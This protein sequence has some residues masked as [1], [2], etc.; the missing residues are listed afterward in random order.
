MGI[1]RCGLL[2]LLGAALLLPGCDDD[3]APPTFEVRISAEPE[4]GGN[5]PLT[6]RFHAPNNGPLEVDYTYAW[7]FGG[8]ATSDEAEPEHTFATPGEHTVSVT[9]R[10]GGASG[11]TSTT[12]SLAPPADLAVEEPGFQ[13]RRVQAGEALEATWLLR[14]AGADPAAGW[15]LQAFASADQ[16]FDASDLVIYERRFEAGPVDGSGTFTFD[17]PDTLPSGDYFVGVVADPDGR[18]GDSNRANNVAF[19]TFTLQVRNPT[20]DG[21]DLVPC[22]LA[23]PAFDRLPPDQVPIAQ[24]GDQL[25]VQVCM[26]NVGDGVVPVAGYGLF[27]SADEVFDDGDLQVGRRDGFALGTGD[28][29]T[30]DDLID[31]PAMDAVGT[32]HLLVVADAREAVG[33]QREDNNTRAWPG[34]FALAEAGQVAGVDLALTELS[35][36]EDRAFWGQQLTGTL[37]LANRGD[38]AVERSFVIRLFAVPTGPGDA[39]QLRS[40]NVPGFAAGASEAFDLQLPVNRRLAAGS[41]V[42]RGEVDPGGSTDDVNPANNQRTLQRELQL[43]G[44]PDFDLVMEAVGFAPAQ[45]DAGDQ[46][47]VTGQVSNPGVDASGG[48]EVAVV[49]SADARLDPDDP[50]LDLT[51]VASIPGGMTAAIERTVVVPLDLDQAVDTWQVILVADPANRL[52]GERSEEN[53]AG[54]APTPLVVQGAMG[55]CAEDQANEP[56]DVRA[57][58]TAVAA[59]TLQ[60]L[61]LCDDADW[62][63]V[64]VGAGQVLEVAVSHDPAAGRA[65]LRVVDGD[66]AA[67]A[68]GEGEAGQVGAFVEPR[69]GA[70]R[71]YVEVTADG[72]LAYDL[73]VTL[74]DAADAP[75]LRLSGV[76][77]QPG[78]VEPGGSFLVRHTVHNLGL[79]AAGESQIGVALVPADGGAPIALPP[80]TTAALEGGQRVTD[81]VRVTLPQ[82]VPDGLYRVRLTAD[83]AETVDEAD[84]ANNVAFGTLRV[85]EAQACPEDDFEPNASGLEGPALGA[86][87]LPPGEHADLAACRGNDDW[88]Q[89]AVAEG[90]RLQVTARFD[91]AQGDLELALYGPDGQTVLD[92][93]ESFRDEESVVLLRAPAAG[94]YF[95]RVYLS[96][97]DAINTSNGYRLTVAVED[98]DDCMDDGFEPNGNRDSA[99]LLPDGN[100]DLMLCAGDEDWFRF[101]IPVGNTV[102]FQVASGAAGV[103]IALFGPDGALIEEDGR[104]I[105]H[106]A[107]R[108]GE[109]RLRAAVVA[110][111]PVVYSL[112]VAGVSGTDLEV[113]DVALSSAQAEAGQDLR[114]VTTIANNRGDGAVNVRVRYLLSDDGLPSADDRVVAE[115]R[116]PALPGA[117]ETVVTQ[118]VTLPLDAAAGARFLVVD[119]D[120][121]REVADLRP[122]NNRGAAALEVVGACVDDDDRENEGPRSATPLAPEDERLEDGVLCAFTEDWF[123]LPVAAAGAVTV[124]LAFPHAQGDL[125]LQVFDGQAD[126]L[127]GESRTEGDAEEV[128][129]Q[130]AAPGDLLIRVDGFLDARNTYTLS[131]TLP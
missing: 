14:N 9:V 95:V 46:I 65:A 24:L 69:A 96:A 49:L 5:A 66:D 60:G 131:W 30:F 82:L 29:A 90:Q 35:V 50:V 8:G 54:F 76:S 4:L 57:Q 37:R 107:V 28:Q 53:N 27:L 11:K 51:A 101:N 31:L 117:A 2:A 58:A 39:V 126:R 67:L 41:Y 33:E 91:N 128:V 106:Q 21:P 36:N 97:G 87:A 94:Q 12:F 86:A 38:A 63:E 48:F 109:Y 102:S 26:T 113:L 7:D 47:T 116:V 6:V 81:S 32:W 10:A 85:D 80:G 42:I 1:A 74:T 119:V 43:G 99:A 112:T 108:T 83:V 105:T 123:R 34:Q 64:Q 120:P 130:V 20:E 68:L 72:P 16:T 70:Y 61:G 114:V 111:E 23:I 44:E 122:G 127:L 55:G 104:R 79:A 15:R 40:L 103:R 18:V 88:Y 56:N 78:V 45:V 92:T 62:F 118:R 59:G 77:A 71:A 124:R 3:P 75:D 22:G 13:P 52:T 89:V 73:A 110:A 93:S 125:D 17:L 115:G 25:A 98:A 84:E 19:A 100:H 121:E 129:V